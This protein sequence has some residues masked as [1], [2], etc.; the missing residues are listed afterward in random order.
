V[1]LIDDWRQA[2]RFLSVQINAVC[3]AAAVIWT[4]LPGDQQTSML[5]WLGFKPSAMVAAAFGAA[6]IARL[7]A[8][9]A[10]YPRE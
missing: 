3:A 10:L 2:W 5:A 1:K 9:P 8:Q 4:G 6:T 7:I